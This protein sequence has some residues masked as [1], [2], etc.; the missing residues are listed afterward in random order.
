M[1]LTTY[2]EI[3]W[4]GSGKSNNDPEDCVL[5]SAAVKVLDTYHSTHVHHS[6][7]GHHPASPNSSYISHPLR[8][9]PSVNS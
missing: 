7:P 5:Y 3:W 1:T 6:D 9:S 4:K 2:L 8:R